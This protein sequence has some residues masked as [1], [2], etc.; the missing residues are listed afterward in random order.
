MERRFNSSFSHR[1]SR[2]EGL[3]LYLKEYILL[4]AF[5]SIGIVLISYILNRTDSK[6]SKILRYECGEEEYKDGNIITLIYYKIA[7]TYL[8]FDIETILLFPS[9]LIIDLSYSNFIVIY[10]FIIILLIG[11][12]VEYYYNIYV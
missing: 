10:L 11:L 2:A 12:F 5:L 8:V 3:Y 6:N 4:G 7:V 9:S 1:I